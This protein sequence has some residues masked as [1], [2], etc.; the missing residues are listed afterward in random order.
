MK[1]KIAA[2]IV[3]YNPDLYR[4]QA[5]LDA[6]ADQVQEVFLIDNGSENRDKIAGLIEQY[7]NCRLLCNPSNMG[8][9]YALNR[10]MEAADANGY[11]WLL[12]L[13]DDSVCD[14]DMVQKLGR[15]RKLK[16]AAII[17]PQARDD[18]MVRQSSEMDPGFKGSEADAK[19]RRVR[20]CITAGALTS[21]AAWRAVGGFD[22]TMFIDFVDIE[23]C[24]RLRKAGYEIWQISHTYVHQ[25]YGAI[26]GSFT[27]LG[28]RFYLFNYS[29]FRVYYSVR[30][31]IYCMKKH[32]DYTGTIKP[33]VFLLGYIGK[34]IIF[35][36]NRKESVIAVARGIKDGVSLKGMIK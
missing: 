22:E 31:Q 1:E 26:S 18:H 16:R 5:N 13:D 6:V 15:H 2:G 20:D 11:G 30:N 14:R 10:L 32:R 27:L 34:R 7:D 8:I 3:L 28:K 21:V 4:L 9:A 25:Q 36:K 19:F 12:T 17:C 33:L 23:F 29:P 24:I 35:E